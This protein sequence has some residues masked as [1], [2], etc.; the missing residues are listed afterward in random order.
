MAK[1]MQNLGIKLL[2]FMGVV[3]VSIFIF[4][5]KAGAQSCSGGVCSGNG[6]QNPSCTRGEVCKWSCGFKADGS[7]WGGG[8]EAGPGSTCA[9]SG[10][11]GDNFAQ[12]CLGSR[13]WANI[14]DGL[15][16]A[17]YGGPYDH[18]QGELD[19]F[20]R[21]ACPNSNPSTA[22]A[23]W[24]PPTCSNGTFS[25][26]TKT[27]EQVCNNYGDPGKGVGTTQ[28][29]GI[30]NFICTSGSMNNAC[31]GNNLRPY[32]CQSTTAN[33]TTLN[34]GD[35]I[36]V[37]ST[38]KV[39]VKK[40]MFAFFN[41]DNNKPDGSPKLI[42]F[43]GSDY[44]PV[45]TLSTAQTQAS[46]TFNFS[47]L[48]RPDTNWTGGQIP[49]RIQVNGYFIDDNNNQSLPEPACVAN[50]TLGEPPS[51]TV[52]TV[53]SCLNTGDLNGDG[54][55]NDADFTVWENAFLGGTSLSGCGSSVPAKDKWLELFNAWRTH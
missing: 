33:K 26:C 11:G 17:G 50:F 44:A 45:E 14:D 36:T 25:G 39:G 35:S 2:L 47:E 10:T 19:A 23:A 5:P 53:D 9:C 38:A 20:N 54:S 51:P 41:N 1:T 7:C 27:G 21:G 43:G 8:W 28:Q 6:M 29:W 22:P 31:R 13:T 40:F 46:K 30:C 24:I 55:I 48:S 12:T 16:Q 49:R 32:L 52:P 18:S 34:S 42:A 37:T 3:L 15:R 4:S